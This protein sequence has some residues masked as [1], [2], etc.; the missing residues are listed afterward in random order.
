MQLGKA[1]RKRRYQVSAYGR[2]VSEDMKAL[3]ATAGGGETNG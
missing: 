3:P 2:E 1:P